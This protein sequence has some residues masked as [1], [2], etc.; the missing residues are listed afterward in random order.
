MSTRLYHVD[1]GPKLY[2]VDLGLPVGADVPVGQFRLVHT[3]HART[4]AQIDRYGPFVLPAT[5]HLQGHE[6]FE[7]EVTDGVSSKAAV[8]VPYNDRY[9]LSLVLRPG[10]CSGH[11]IVVTC[12]LNENTD[13]H[14]TL[15]A[16]RY[17]RP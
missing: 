3:Q 14:Q 16:G 7:L 6:T 13:L 4:Q 15:K 2:H 1:L 5:L 8:R 11:V 17:T 9:D 10:A 12:W